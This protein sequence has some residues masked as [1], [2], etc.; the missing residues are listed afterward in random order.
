MFLE[1]WLIK[2]GFYNAIGLYIIVW[3][4]LVLLNLKLSIRFCI[5]YS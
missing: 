1:K 2:K 3:F 5:I 4:D